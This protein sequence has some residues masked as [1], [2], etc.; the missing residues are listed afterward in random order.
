[1]K[2]VSQI[3][4]WLVT[5]GKL[6][7][8]QMRKLVEEGILLKDDVPFSV[9]VEG[10]EDR[11]WHS[12]IMDMYQELVRVMGPPEHDEYYKKGAV[13]ATKVIEAKEQLELADVICK[14]RD[15]ID[16]LK[17]QINWGHEI[18]DL[19]SHDDQ[20][21]NAVIEQI[22]IDEQ[23]VVTLSVVGRQV[24]AVCPH[25]KGDYCEPDFLCEK[26]YRGMDLC[27]NLKPSAK[28]KNTYEEDIPW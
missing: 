5:E 3:A 17:E 15:K 19:Q 11:D 2:A 18:Y 21:R 10:Y 1:M 28:P 24:F 12:L 13:A 25:C 8:V 23:K 6:D 7:K 14:M 4:K 27:N 26:C 20:E 22:R 16:D 9:F